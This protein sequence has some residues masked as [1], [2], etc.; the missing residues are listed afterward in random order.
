MI[1]REIPALKGGFMS[2]QKDAHV[3]PPVPMVYEHVPAEPL[4]WEYHVLSVD[5]RE[6]DLPT[7]DEL[8]ELGEQGW[9]LVAVL[10]TQRSAVPSDMPLVMS[11]GQFGEMM[12]A[13]RGIL[14]YHFVR[15]KRA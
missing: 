1:Y 6:Y 3:F 8:N 9:L 5:L 10:Q 7:V 4:K 12:Q 14:H 15:D 11:P 13:A 2:E